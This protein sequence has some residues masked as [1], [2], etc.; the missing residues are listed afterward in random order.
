MFAPHSRDP[1]VSVITPVLNGGFVPLLELTLRSVAAQ[2]YRNLEHIVIDGGSTDQTLDILRRFRSSIPFRWVTE[3]DSGM[4]SAINKGIA[5]ARGDVLAYLNADD[6]Y[7]PWTIES[8]VGRLKATSADIVFGDVLML[9]KRD[10][11]ARSAWMQFYPE[12][13]A[14]VYAFEVVMGQPSVFWKRQFTQSIGGFDERLRYS[15]DFEYWLRASGGGFRYQRLDDALALE[16]QH[17]HTL[18]SPLSRARSRG[19]CVCAQ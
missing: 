8:V 12:F 11:R 6:L 7:L 19:D 9:S 17:E 13:N 16:V 18:S 4:Y 10:A 5:M 14:R 15:G 1:L 3:K 2:K